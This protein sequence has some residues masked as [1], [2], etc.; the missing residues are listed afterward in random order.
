VLIS[1]DP[2][3]PR[4]PLSQGQVINRVNAPPQTTVVPQR[5]E[6]TSLTMSTA[7]Q[8][9]ERFTSDKQTVRTALCVEIRDPRRANGPVALKDAI[10]DANVPS[11][12]LHSDF[13]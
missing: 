1:Q 2:Y 6:A 11:K 9:P 8:A 13:K 5:Q 12:T 4:A 3:A 7:I 10:T